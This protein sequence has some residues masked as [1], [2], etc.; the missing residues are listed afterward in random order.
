MNI[1]VLLGGCTNCLKH[2]LWMGLFDYKGNK[3][4]QN[5]MKSVFVK[6]NKITK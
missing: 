2:T 4:Y 6:I 1:G 5:S 3:K